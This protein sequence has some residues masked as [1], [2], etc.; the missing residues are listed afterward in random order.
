MNLLAKVCGITTAADA[1]FAHAQGA[2]MLGFVHHP[3]SPRHCANI[4]AA[5]AGLSYKGV[6]VMVG[7]DPAPMIAQA[8]AAGLAWVQPHSGEARDEVAAALSAAGFQILLPWPDEPDQPF[9]QA[10]LYLWE[11]S[12]AI[13]GVAG[14]SGQ[15]HLSLHPPPGPFLL[16]GGLDGP[17][18]QTRLANLP[19]ETKQNLRGVDAASRLEAA[20]GRKDPRKVIAYLENAHALHL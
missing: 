3:K 8:N 9:I 11:P 13:T 12:P 6:L 20:P 5:S 14:G 7:E 16:A 17:S 2:D 18:L 4:P 19:A 10:D 1:R 15:P